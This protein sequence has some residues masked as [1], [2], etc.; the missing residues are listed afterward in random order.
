METAQIV[1][2]MMRLAAATRDTSIDSDVCMV[3]L[4]NLDDYPTVDIVAVCREMEAKEEW[5]PKV[6]GLR[7]AIGAFRRKRQDAEEAERR[8]KVK[9]LPEPV[10]SPEK[11][12][13]LMAKLRAHTRRHR[14]PNVKVSDVG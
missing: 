1:A 9:L 3:Y 12:A 7:K 14:M 8:A 13:E 11:Q 2:A 10:I 4:G 5:F 6:A